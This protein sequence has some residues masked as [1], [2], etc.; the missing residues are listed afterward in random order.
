MISVMDGRREKE[1]EGNEG[2]GV[3]DALDDVRRFVCLAHR[4]SRDGK[5]VLASK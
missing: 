1:G 4:A 2:G 5:L 3:L